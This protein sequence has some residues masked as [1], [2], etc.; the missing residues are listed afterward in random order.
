MQKRHRSSSKKDT[1]VSGNTKTETF[2]CPRGRAFQITLNQANLSEKVINYLLGLKSLGYL[3]GTK[4]IAPTTNHEHCH[5]Y[6]HFNN[7]I[8]LSKKKLFNA[9]IEKARGSPQE[10]IKYIKK[11][12]QPEKRGEI[13]IE[14]GTEP[15][16]GGK[17]IKAVKEMSHE[18]RMDLPLVY[19]NIVNKIESLEKNELKIEDFGKKVKVWWIYGES[20]VG[21][22]EMAKKLIK[23]ILQNS[24][25]PIPQTFNLIKYESTFWHGVGETSKIALY[26]DFR[27]NHM[28]PSELINLIDYNVH[29]MNIKGGSIKNY[30]NYIIITSIQNPDEIYKN[31]GDEPRK[32]WIRR[33]EIY[34]IDSPERAAE[35]LESIDISF[36]EKLI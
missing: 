34:Y 14:W 22:T 1:E 29:P 25:I 12:D 19:Y 21:K 9:H 8:S 4:E 15:K 6:A 36:P 20:G 18:E 28:K 31:V 2:V 24:P 5:F 10:N 23:H 7:P 27:D 16:Q 35:Y 26:D 17:T 3:I 30:Y 13:I 11:E 33:M 32:Q